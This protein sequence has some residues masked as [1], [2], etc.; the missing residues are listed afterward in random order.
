MTIHVTVRERIAAAEADAF[1]VCGNSGDTV[2]FDLDSEWEAYPTRTARFFCRRN[3]RAF[4]SD[5]LFTG[6]SVTVPVLRNMSEVLIGV[7]AGDIRTT[8]PARVLCV[9][10]ITDGA[11]QH[12]DPAPDVYDQ[13]MEY[14]AGLQRGIVSETF[15]QTINAVS[16]GGSLDFI[17]AEE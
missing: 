3:G 15:L 14:L 12:E 6:D 17:T 4:Y 13:L 10:C 8:T 9:P 7:Y 1:L 2:Q 16:I 5:V 11:P